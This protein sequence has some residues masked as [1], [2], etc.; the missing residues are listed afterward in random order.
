MFQLCTV[1]VTRNIL[2]LGHGVEA[3]DSDGVEG[4][5]VDVGG[6][7][8]AGFFSVNNQYIFLN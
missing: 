5:E 3:V 4:S 1:N 2:Q 8:D 6:A 7:I